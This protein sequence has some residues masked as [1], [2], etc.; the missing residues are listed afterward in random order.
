MN[1]PMQ[2]TTR[3]RTVGGA[4][5]VLASLLVAGCPPQIDPTLDSIQEQVFGPS[6]GS[7]SSCH[8][9]DEPASGLDMS[10]ADATWQTSVDID[11]DE[12]DGVRII[13]GD[14]D[15]SVLYQ[16]LFDELGEIRR[17]PVGTTLD[18]AETRAVRDWIDDG[19]LAD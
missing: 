9:G 6:C 5:L 17:M 18:E 1:V 7:A 15:G 14:A 2:P 12:T 4:L 13:P 11:A 16:V 3:L 8:A 19:A 10:T